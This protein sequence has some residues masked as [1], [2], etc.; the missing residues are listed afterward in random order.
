MFTLKLTLYSIGWQPM[1]KVESLIGLLGR[2]TLSF[3]WWNARRKKGRE[4]RGGARKG[5]ETVKVFNSLNDSIYL[6]LPTPV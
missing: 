5:I 4:R 3:I 2:K 1:W 6:D